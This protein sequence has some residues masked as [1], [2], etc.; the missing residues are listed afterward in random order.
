MYKMF[1]QGNDRGIVKIIGGGLAGVECAWAL[2]KQGFKVIMY[3]MRP[4]N[5]TGALTT[6]LANDAA[7]V[8]GVLTASLLLRLS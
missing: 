7:R 2:L 5:T 8:K 6:R 1:T 4:K 3:E